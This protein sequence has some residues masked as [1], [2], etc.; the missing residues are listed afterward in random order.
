MSDLLSLDLSFKTVAVA[1]LILFA[2]KAFIKGVLRQ[3]WGMICLALG[4][5]AGYFIFQNGSEWIGNVIEHPSGNTVLGASIAGGAAVWMGGKGIVHKIY[6]GLSQ[7]SNDRTMTG[8]LVGAVISLAPTSFLVW[9]VATV[10]RLTGSMSEMSH[11]DSA[12]RAED[13]TPASEIGIVA[14]LRQEL[15]RGWLGDVLKKTDP[16]TTEA[17]HQLASLLV[18]YNDS[19]A[20]ERLKNAHPEIAKLLANE[21]VQR[22]LNDK[23]VRNSVAF[24][25]HSS[26]LLEPDVQRAATDPEVARQ[27][28]YL[29]IQETA[30]QVLYE[31]DPEQKEN[32]AGRRFL[33]RLSGRGRF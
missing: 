30:Q 19:D 24:S 4:G 23:Q 29:N 10:L 5:V 15:D 7:T 3:V 32:P 25:D 11:L 31:P 21:K 33:R 8:R 27:L 6:N 13:G 28:T 12:V 22:V 9:V 16:F 20:W 2:I 26:L 17:G 14:Q 18:L 1:L